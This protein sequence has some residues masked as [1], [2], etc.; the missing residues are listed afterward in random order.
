MFPVAFYSLY[1]PGYLHNYNEILHF[2]L[3]DA[4]GE[5][6]CSFVIDNGCAI[7][8]GRSGCTSL[9]LLLFIMIQNNNM[10]LSDIS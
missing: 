1:L 6:A 2:S 3:L 7:F 5:F 10:T 9:F 8:T 4:S